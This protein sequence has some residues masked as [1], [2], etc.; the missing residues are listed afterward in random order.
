MDTNLSNV[1]MF[2]LYSVYFAMI[3]LVV[4]AICSIF[5]LI[6]VSRQGDERKKYIL[7]KTCTQSFL[8]YTGILVIDVI[9][10]IFF[11]KY[12]N[13]VMENTPI[14]S[15]GLISIIFTVSIFI[16]KRTYGN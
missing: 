14:V 16:N 10:T 5:M 9:Y 4:S 2:Q 13:F 1:Q 6:S 3:F 7:S 8:V 15:L 12:S 11:E